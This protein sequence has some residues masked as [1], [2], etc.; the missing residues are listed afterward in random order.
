MNDPQRKKQMQA[1]HIQHGQMVRDGV[2]PGGSC[3]EWA[4]AVLGRVVSTLTT[5]ADHELNALRDRL[6]GKDGKLLARVKQE[7]DR[8]GIQRP[9]AWVKRCADSES[10][11]AWRGRT[12]ESLPVSQL[13]RLLKMLERRSSSRPAGAATAAPQPA[14]QAIPQ[15]SAPTGGA[16]V[17]LEERGLWGW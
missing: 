8:V 13:Y 9:D 11:R 7:F 15:K 10:F 14:P 3:H 4:S 12:L 17:K 5:L 6:Q 2:L 1:V 16:R